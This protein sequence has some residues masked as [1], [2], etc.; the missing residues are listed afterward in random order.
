LEADLALILPDEEAMPSTPGLLSIQQTPRR[1]SDSTAFTTPVANTS[2]SGA[3]STPLQ[4]PS[5][6]KL[7]HTQGRPLSTSGQAMGISSG[8]NTLDKESEMSGLESTAGILTETEGDLTLGAV[9]GTGTLE[10]CMGNKY[11]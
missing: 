10:K 3:G 6:H 4:T 1:R 9:G 2:F 7:S 11:A 5:Q 8:L